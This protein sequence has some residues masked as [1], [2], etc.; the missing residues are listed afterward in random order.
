MSAFF[1]SK[2]NLETFSRQ[3]IKRVL[4]WTE[5]YE[6][7]PIDSEQKRKLQMFFDK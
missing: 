1:N 4:S 5:R 2:L 7:Y 6:T 3:I